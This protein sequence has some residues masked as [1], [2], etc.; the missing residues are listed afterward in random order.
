MPTD[1]VPP[2]AV[3]LVKWVDLYDGEIATAP[4]DMPP[5]GWVQPVLY[6]DLTVDL[7]IRALQ[8]AALDGGYRPGRFP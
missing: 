8:K 7:L 2:D 4:S 1:T 6:E 5:S 3:Q